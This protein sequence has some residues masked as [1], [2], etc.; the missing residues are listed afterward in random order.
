MGGKVKDAYFAVQE[1]RE[2][3]SSIPLAESVR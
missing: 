3:L 1:S 2:P